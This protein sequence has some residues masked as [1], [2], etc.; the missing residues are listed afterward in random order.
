M[1]EAYARADLVVCRA[2]ATTVAELTAFGK[3]AILVP[4]PY[5]I[6]DHQRGNAEALHE[7]GAAEMIL[8]Q[9]LNGAILAEKIRGYFSQRPRLE[10]MAAAALALGRPDAA[11]RIVDECCALAQA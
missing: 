5:A 4:Y 8:D 1:D 3:P 7:R 10:A 2:G 11:R 6:Y 9:E